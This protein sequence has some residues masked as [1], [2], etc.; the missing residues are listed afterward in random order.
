VVV[1]PYRY[2]HVQK[3]ELERQWTNMMAQGAIRPSTS[4][5]SV[6]VILVKKSNSS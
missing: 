4:A 2:A 5:F 6:P 1:R 3:G